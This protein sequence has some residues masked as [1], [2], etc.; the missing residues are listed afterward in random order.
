LNR[1]LSLHRMSVNVASR[2]GVPAP[3]Q[4]LFKNVQSLSPGIAE[5]A[6]FFASD[7]ARFLEQEELDP[8][9]PLI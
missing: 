9:L 2:Y 5:L 8:E 6:D 3:K 4:I 1:R 7:G